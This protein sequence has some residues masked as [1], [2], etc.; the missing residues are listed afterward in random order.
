MTIQSRHPLPVRLFHWT[1]APL[2][3]AL[4]VSGFYI[5][6]PP[7]WGSMRVARKIHVIAGFLFTC[8]F[9]AR[10]Y[11]G[12]IRRDWRMIVPDRY[13]LKRLPHFAKYELYLTS[14]KP[15]FRKYNPGKK[16][17]YTA[18]PLLAL[19]ML[20]AGFLLY[21]PKVFARPIKWIGGLNR[22]RSIAYHTALFTAATIAYHIYLNLTD[23]VGIL[24]SIFTG[25]YERGT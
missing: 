4:L 25:Y 18:W 1:L 3:I 14:K 20:P 23:S 16:F 2:A 21:A 10:V 9:I 6:S 5:S 19:V 8:G 7:K 11:Y 15:E 22:L 17:L 24:K 13:D 12:I